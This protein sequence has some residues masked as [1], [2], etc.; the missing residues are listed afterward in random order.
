LSKNFTLKYYACLSILFVYE[1]KLCNIL[2]FMKS[3]R[4]YQVVARKMLVE[5]YKAKIISGDPMKDIKKI[6]RHIIS[7]ETQYIESM[8]ISLKEDERTILRLQNKASCLQKEIEERKQLVEEYRNYLR[9][10]SEK[11]GANI[12][13]IPSIDQQLD[14]NSSAS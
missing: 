12:R 9:C 7:N 6:L 1:G 5:M 2:F 3:R 4:K 11:S 14:T 13:L 8:G 10:G